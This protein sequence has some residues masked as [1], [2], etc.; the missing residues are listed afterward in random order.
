MIVVGLAD[1][2][3]SIFSTVPGIDLAA[4]FER[5]IPTTASAR[6]QPSPLP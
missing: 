2:K 3:N 6:V 5:E 4:A 1:E